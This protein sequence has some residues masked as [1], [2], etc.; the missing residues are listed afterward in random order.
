M[1]NLGAHQKTVVWMK[2]CGGPHVAIPLFIATLGNCK[3]Q[4]K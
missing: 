4:K 2:R 1:S 3:S